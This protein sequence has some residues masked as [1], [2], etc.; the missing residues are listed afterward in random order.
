MLVL[1]TLTAFE[2]AT[3]MAHLPGHIEESKV[4]SKSF[5][6]LAKVEDKVG[7]E[8]DNRIVAN[9]DTKPSKNCFGSG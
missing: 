7:E 2:V 6:E 4:A 5:F 9:D 1:I 8:N 3:P